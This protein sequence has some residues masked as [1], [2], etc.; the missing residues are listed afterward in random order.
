ME[1]CLNV[2]DYSSKKEQ[3][4]PFELILCWQKAVFFLFR[5]SKIELMRRACKKSIRIFVGLQTV[6]FSF[7]LSN[8]IYD[9]GWILSD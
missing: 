4:A 9:K 7:F 2:S 3:F 1:N 6:E 5:S 8:L